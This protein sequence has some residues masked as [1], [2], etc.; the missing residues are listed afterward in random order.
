VK[1]PEVKP[2]PLYRKAATPEE[3]RKLLEAALEIE[4]MLRDKS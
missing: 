3:R 1:P 4:N 2:V